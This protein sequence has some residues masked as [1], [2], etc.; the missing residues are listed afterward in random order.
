M[1]TY[2]SPQILYSLI[3]VIQEVDTSP[4][5]KVELT[6]INF[7]FLLSYGTPSD[8]PFVI[9][10]PNLNQLSISVLYNH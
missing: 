7:L 1:V 3:I 5:Y 8:P 10:S 6:L 2:T 9:N 4:N